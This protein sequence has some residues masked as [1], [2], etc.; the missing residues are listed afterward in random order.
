MLRLRPLQKKPVSPHLPS[1]LNKLWRG[2][3]IPRQ[4]ASVTVGRKTAGGPG[5][6]DIGAV[7]ERRE[8]ARS[9][10]ARNPTGA[11]KKTSYV[12][13]FVLF[14]TSGVFF[15]QVPST[16]YLNRFTSPHFLSL[17]IEVK[18]TSWCQKDFCRP[19]AVTNGCTLMGHTFIL[20][21]LPT[22]DIHL[23]NSNLA[24]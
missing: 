22:H 8:Q 12:V 15:G 13:N 21:H 17:S 10:Q 14:H 11:I 20:L 7:S 24:W 23:K 18:F 3:R 4:R 1:W 19:T 9:Q 16:S 2:T 6:P 5:S